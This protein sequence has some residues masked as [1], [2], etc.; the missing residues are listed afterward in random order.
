MLA[1]RRKPKLDATCTKEAPWTAR[2]PI[3]VHDG[4]GAVLWTGDAYYVRIKVGNSGKT[5]AE[6]V[7]VYAAKLAKLGADNKFADIPT[8]LPLNMK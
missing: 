8:F 2:T 4:Q 1:W 3:I 7:Q 5:R 6:K